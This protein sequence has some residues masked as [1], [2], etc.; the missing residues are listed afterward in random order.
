MFPILTMALAKCLKNA[1]LDVGE[2]A[3]TPKVIV[4][5]D[6]IRLDGKNY[7]IWSYRMH[8]Y[9]LDNSLTRVLYA[10]CPRFLVETEAS[11]EE[12]AISRA[13]EEI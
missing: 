11:V 12:I 2:P 9:V 10:P 8:S 1:E 5:V 6:N 3:V 4:A 13:A 7:N